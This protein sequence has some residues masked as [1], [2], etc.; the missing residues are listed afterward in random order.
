MEYLFLVITTSIWGSLYVVTKIALA[1][2]PPVTMLMLRYAIASIAFGILLAVTKRKINFK[3][4]DIG[5]ILFIGIVG[6]FLGV[7]A[8]VVGTKY[9]GASLASLVNALNPV[10]ITIFAAVYLKERIGPARILSIL[11][12]LAGVYIIIA[13]AR[14]VELKLGVVFSIVSVILWSLSSVLVK[15]ISTEYDPLAVTAAALWIATAFSI[16]CSIIE[17]AHTAQ[18]NLFSPVSIGCILYLGIIGTAVPNLLWNLSLSRLDASICS[19]FYPV[20]PL[21]SVLLGG[22]LLGEKMTVSFWIGAALIIS[23]LFLSIAGGRKH[24]K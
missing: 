23:G 3:K 21:V 1:E 15:K 5:S 20:Q 12:G 4:K 14:G 19:L 18:Y 2:I 7:A 8:Q 16:P 17:L 9:G 11:L 6:Y 13:G 24:K 22:L 10:F